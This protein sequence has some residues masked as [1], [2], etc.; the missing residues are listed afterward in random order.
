MLHMDTTTFKTTLNETQPPADFSLSLQALWWDAKGNWGK[1]H[2]CVQAMEGTRD[3]KIGAK[4]HAY[5]HRKEGDVPNADY[6]YRRAGKPVFTGLLE[7]EWT[8]LVGGVA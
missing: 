5:L 2:E 1:A 3:D 7:E 8:E 4:V 6:W